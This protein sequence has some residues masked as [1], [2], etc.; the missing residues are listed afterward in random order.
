MAK[1][2]SRMSSPESLRTNQPTLSRKACSGSLQQRTAVALAASQQRS[3]SPHASS[4]QPPP[5]REGATSARA[6]SSSSGSSGGGAGATDTPSAVIPGPHMAGGP[7][8]EVRL[9]ACP[10][11]PPL[12][13]RSAVLTRPRLGGRRSPRRAEAAG[14]GLP[15]R[16]PLFLYMEA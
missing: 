1:S 15:P 7:W 4:A 2:T 8:R 9:S 5:P 11:A 10:L 13:L 6:S 12:A 3:R 16:K 14:G